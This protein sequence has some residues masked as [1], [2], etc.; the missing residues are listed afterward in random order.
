MGLISQ[1]V[2]QNL[3]PYDKVQ[4]VEPVAV[5]TD[6]ELIEDAMIDKDANTVMAGGEI[7]RTPQLSLSRLFRWGLRQARLLLNSL[8]DQR[9]RILWIKLITS[10]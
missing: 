10:I 4:L 3:K 1:G 8:W 2:V 9:W 6:G 5:D 7:M